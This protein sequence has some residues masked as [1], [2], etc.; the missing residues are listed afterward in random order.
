M[1]LIGLYQ[2]LFLFAY[3]SYLYLNKAI[4]YTYLSELVWLLGILL[5]IKYFKQL[6]IAWGKVLGIL[7]FLLLVN[8]LQLLRGFAGNGIVDTIRDSFVL[9]YGGF[10]FIAFLFWDQQTDFFNR[11]VK[12]YQYFPVV[13]SITYFIKSIYPDINDIELFKGIPLLLYKNGDM[14]VHLLITVMLVLTGKLTW[15]NQRLTVANYILLI[16]LFLLTATYSRGGL[17]AFVLPLGF[18][19]YRSRKSEWVQN[20]KMYF[21]WI[22][23]VIALA[24]P[25]YLSTKIKVEDK[26]YGRQVGLSQLRDNV[27]SIFVRDAAKST[28]DLDDNVTWRLLWWGKIIDYTVYG[29]YFYTGKGLGVSL[30]E[31]DDINTDD[32]LRSPHNFSLTILARYGVPVFLVW[33]LFLF[34][35]FQPLFQKKQSAQTL[36][37]GSALLG[38]FI[39]ASFD[40]SLEGPMMA[41]PFWSLLGI[42]LMEQIKVNE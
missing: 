39:N 33:L 7:S 8:G 1:K 16:Y 41:F 21:K 26:D 25:L 22:P 5:F 40:V 35:L 24:L 38:I 20:I 28:G 14:S 29:P 42:Y 6:N 17:L 11:I 30:A 19:V 12:L 4:A 36:L 9:N 10:V 34:Y 27:V 32:S 31:D 15:N 13:V 23:L 37:L 2:Y 18:F 3:G